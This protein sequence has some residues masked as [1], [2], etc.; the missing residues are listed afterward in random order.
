M[1]RLHQSDLFGEQQTIMHTA[2]DL[3]I[4]REVRREAVAWAIAHGYDHREA[5][6]SEEITEPLTG[7]TVAGAWQELGLRVRASRS[8]WP[9]RRGAWRRRS[10]TTVCSRRCSERVSPQLV[11]ASTAHRKATTL[12]PER[13]ALALQEL[14]DPG[15][16]LLIEWSAPRN[17]DIEDRAA[18]RQASPHWSTG[19]QRLLEARLKK[20]LSGQTLDPDEDDPIESFRCQFLN[21]WLPT[22]VTDAGEPVLDIGVW[23]AAHGTVSPDARV[24][25]AIEDYFGRGR[26]GRRRR[27]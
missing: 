4:A 16:T 19:R 9:T 7:S 5:N 3:Q 15:T 10:S 22:V 11:L 12:F 14:D 6:G 26:C 18:W 21:S 13:R 17:C 27:P 23:M 25:A 2:K 20:V 1:W 24:Y 8:R